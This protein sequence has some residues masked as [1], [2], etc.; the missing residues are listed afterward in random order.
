MP[1]QDKNLSDTE[2]IRKRCDPVLRKV[3]EL[4]LRRGDGALRDLARHFGVRSHATS[5]KRGAVKINPD[6]FRNKMSQFGI[7]LDPS[8]CNVLLSAFR[9]PVGYLLVSDFIAEVQKTLNEVRTA[10]VTRAF[11]KLDTQGKGFV[12]TEDI[13]GVIDFGSL[14]E[15]RA[16]NLSEEDA[17]RRFMDVFDDKTQPDG[18]ITED[19]FLCYYAAVS[20]NVANDKDFVRMVEGAWKLKITTEDPEWQPSTSVQALADETAALSVSRKVSPKRRHVLVDGPEPRDL[21]EVTRCICGYTG[22]VPFAQERYGETFQK[23]QLSAPPI[24][25]RVFTLVY[26]DSAE[27]ASFPSR[28]GN[29]ANT[30]NFKFA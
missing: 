12:T 6:D 8:E 15:V 2:L 20:V 4:A 22:H 11:R 30:H 3:R 1:A 23:T 27:G 7:A 5:A 17:A 24:G 25:K 10:V 13:K 26:P 16:G 18:K 28:T 21:G 9:D 14:P 19:E 29:K